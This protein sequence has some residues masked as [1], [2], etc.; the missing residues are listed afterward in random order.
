MRAYECSLTA[1]GRATLLE[2]L[3]ATERPV[4]IKR[5]HGREEWR[6]GGWLRYEWCIFWRQ[7]E[8]DIWSVTFGGNFKKPEMLEPLFAR[9]VSMHKGCSWIWPERR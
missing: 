9:T 2:L 8:A 6:I 1:V 5:N 3:L 7:D 4:R